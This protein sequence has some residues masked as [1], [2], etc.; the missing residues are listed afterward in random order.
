MKNN[1]ILFRFEI[2]LKMALHTLAS[3]LDLKPFIRE[4]ETILNRVCDSDEETDSENEFKRP[5]FEEK[6]LMYNEN[7][8]EDRKWLYNLLL[9]DTESDSEI[10]DED[11]YVGEMLKEHVREKKY[12]EKYF[13]NP[14]VSIKK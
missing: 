4:A 7:V 10:T 12:R 3:A 13:Q 14:S 5:T 1:N 9:S 2:F 6:E 8:G 11:R